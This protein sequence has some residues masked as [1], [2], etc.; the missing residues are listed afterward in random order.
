MA[1]ASVSAREADDP[2][3]LGSAARREGID[4]ARILALALVAA[5]HL[6]L[7]VVDRPAFGV[8][9]AALAAGVVGL[10]GPRG[11]SLAV[12][13]TTM[14]LAAWLLLRGSPATPT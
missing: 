3:H 10:E 1:L 13:C 14:F 9:L 5:G 6:T 7:A 12:V 2:G 4:V 8:A 11:V